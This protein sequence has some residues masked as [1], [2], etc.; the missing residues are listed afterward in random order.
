MNQRSPSQ[1]SQ[2]VTKVNNYTPRGI[3]CRDVP[4]CVFT[5]L[6]WTEITETYQNTVVLLQIPVGD[7]FWYFL[8]KTVILA[9]F[10]HI[11]RKNQLENHKIHKSSALTEFVTIPDWYLDYKGSMFAPFLSFTKVIPILI[12]GCF[13]GFSHFF[14]SR[15][16]WLHL[17]D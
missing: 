5:R 7:T 12:F 15:R 4:F 17:F 16:L 9:F 2:T 13:Y 14:V 8:T 6:R 10:K 3:P 11:L 1:N